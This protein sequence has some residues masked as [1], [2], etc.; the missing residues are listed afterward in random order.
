MRTIWEPW[1]SFS[2]YGPDALLGGEADASLWN[3]PAFCRILSLYDPLRRD[4]RERRSVQSGETVYVRTA[5]DFF[6]EETDARREDAWS[7]IR[8]RPD[9][10]FVL[11]TEQPYRISRILPRDWGEGWDNVVLAVIFENQRQ[12]KERA[13]ALLKLPFRH[14]AILALPLTGPLSVERYLKTG[15]VEQVLCG[16]DRKEGAD[17]CDFQWICTL[18]DEC[19]RY[20]VYFRFLET[21]SVFIR[22]GTVY[23][24]PDPVIQRQTALLSGIYETGNKPNFRLPPRGGNDSPENQA[25]PRRFRRV[26]LSCPSSFA[27]AGC[28]CCGLCSG[29]LYSEEEFCAEK[30]QG[31]RTGTG[32]D[33]R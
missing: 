5:P 14:K 11:A 25:E 23:H 31:F 3:Q 20:G 22:G 28:R 10:I 6:S 7:V 26:C 30:V 2:Q 17:P 21:G 18:H 29:K 24:I 9:V 12:A 8:E 32:K 33:T 13:S 27:C 4:G 16:G 1:R 19:V 15:C